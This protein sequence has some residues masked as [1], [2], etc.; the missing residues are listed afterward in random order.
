MLHQARTLVGLSKFDCILALSQNH[1]N[2]QMALP[3]YG[4]LVPKVIVLQD[5]REGPNTKQLLY[6]C[7]CDAK[8]VYDKRMDMLTNF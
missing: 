3:I 4:R 1:D 6:T 2:F 5:Y 8:T 7:Q